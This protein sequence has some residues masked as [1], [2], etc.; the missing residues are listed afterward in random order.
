MKAIKPYGTVCRDA[1]TLSQ[2]LPLPQ[3]TS[4]WP[5]PGSGDLPFCGWLGQQQWD[6]G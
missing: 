3:G 1:Q 4:W 2:G 5:Q 6:S